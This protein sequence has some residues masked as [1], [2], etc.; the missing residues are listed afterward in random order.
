[1]KLT[2]MGLDTSLLHQPWGDAEREAWSAACT[3]VA[4]RCLELI[5]V[6]SGENLV[7]AVVDRVESEL[8]GL[9]R[10]LAA[11]GREGKTADGSPGILT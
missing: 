1:M 2:G 9:G 11:Q 8:R 3:T 4:Q 5:M 10:W 6:I 7:C